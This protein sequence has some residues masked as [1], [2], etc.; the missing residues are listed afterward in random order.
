MLQTTA[1]ATDRTSDSA[2]SRART[3]AGNRE[4]EL[5]AEQALIRNFYK[6]QLPVKSAWSW[7]GDTGHKEAAK[8]A[9]QAPP[10]DSRQEPSPDKTATFEAEA[11]ADSSGTLA[12][13]VQVVQKF[14]DPDVQITA[15]APP[16]RGGAEA[17][18]ALQQSADAGQQRTSAPQQGVDAGELA[19]ADHVTAQ[20]A[21]DN[22][23]AADGSGPAGSPAA[24]PFASHADEHSN[25]FA[26]AV[27]TSAAGA[28]DATSQSAAEP[29]SGA[30]AFAD[31][32]SDAS[33]ADAS[34][35]A[36]AGS[37]AAG[38]FAASGGEATASVPVTPD[39]SASA[40][41]T[42]TSQSALGAQ[43]T[44]ADEVRTCHMEEHVEYGA[45]GVVGW[46][47]NNKQVRCSSTPGKCF[48]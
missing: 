18:D 1:G 40:N 42:A 6:D 30:G 22:Q 12:R 32:S 41:I 29:A 19:A 2:A 39:D 21:A 37:D 7:L 25:A 23:A 36:G 31:M 9:E 48:D 28:D 15:A 27:I 8:H 14:Y 45:P 5:A 34:A 35:S 47:P 46:G 44:P 24:S 4:R 33:T 16:L 17:A 10:V 38:S 3:N 20:A 26:S 13:E 11:A 43:G